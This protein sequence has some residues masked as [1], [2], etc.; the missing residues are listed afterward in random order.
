MKNTCS[1]MLGIVKNIFLDI[2]LT[3]PDLQPEL[4]RCD[5]VLTS[6]VSARGLSFLTM[7]L[8]ECGK[9]LEHSLENNL[10]L[11]ERP[12]YHGRYSASDCRPVFLH[13]L[14]TRCFDEQGYVLDSP[15]PL[16]V[17]SLRQVYLFAKK[18]NAACGSEY[19]VQSVLDYI[20]IE[21]ELPLPRP[22]TWNSDIP[23]WSRPSGHPLYGDPQSLMSSRQMAFFGFEQPETYF[24]QSDWA[25]FRELCS[26]LSAS[27]GE[28]DIWAIRPKH[29]PGVVS[30]PKKGVIKYDF[31]N[32]P[33]KLDAVFPADWFTSVDMTDRTVSNKE[34]PCKLIAVPKTQKGP[35]LIACEPTA[36]QWIQGGIQRWLETAIAHSPLGLSIDFRDQSAS[37]ALALEASGT[38]DYATVDL[39][40]ASDRLSARLV[41]YM[42]QGNQ[43]LLDALHASRS[44]SVLIPQDLSPDGSERLIVMK[45]FAAMGSATTFPIQTIIFTMIGHFALMLADGTRDCSLQSLRSRA[46]RLRV[47]GDDIIIDTKA[48][49]YLVA[50]LTE[51]GLKVNESKSFHKGGFREA[52]GMDAFQGVDVTP[53][54]MRT[55]HDP[56]N[57]ETLV[58]VIEVSNNFYRKGW[59]NTSTAILKTVDDKIIADLAVTSKGTGSISLFTFGSNSK[60]PARSRYN[61]ML[62]RTEYLTYTL[63]QHPGV[64]QGTGEASLIQY[65]TE[66][67]GREL[68]GSSEPLASWS[69]GQ[70]RKPT[71]RIKR[72]WEPHQE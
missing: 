49:E 54:Y 42:L 4:A 67:P 65:F 14:W 40:A 63:D 31:L 7:T 37:Q 59:W 61:K 2:S 62:H 25:L 21:E 35:R 15:D 57:P 10:T 30:D 53:A 29:G 46:H 9:F 71:L 12:P 43:S 68:W 58:S 22:D 47:F 55:L 51:C 64:D 60:Y 34:H 16:A 48:Y 72:R 45:K 23:Q 69:S 50:L 27:F 33:K 20:R 36:H 24:K 44:R 19:V 11:T 70:A 52:C 28:L 13:G 8:P 18:W 26:R 3:F 41:E 66:S 17:F 39:S 5:N 38:G 56:S 6:A 32:W 1:I